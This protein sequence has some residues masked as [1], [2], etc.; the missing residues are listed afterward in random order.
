[1][2]MNHEEDEWLGTGNDLNS[3]VGDPM[4]ANPRSGDFTLADDSPALALGFIP[5]DTSDVGPRPEGQ[6]D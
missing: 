3:L 6:R 1:M 5:F 2:I 4:C